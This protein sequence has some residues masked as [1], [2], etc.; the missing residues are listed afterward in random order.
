[1]D[2]NDKFEQFMEKV[3]K[4]PLPQ[5]PMARVR[6]LAK[7]LAEGAQRG[8]MSASMIHVFK[9]SKEAGQFLYNILEKRDTVLA[10][11][12]QTGVRMEHLVKMCMKDPSKAREL[13]VRQDSYWLNHV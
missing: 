1:M 7:E 3:L 8:G 11:G 5:N 2:D 12:S 9:S 13:L 6:T 10:K 4:R